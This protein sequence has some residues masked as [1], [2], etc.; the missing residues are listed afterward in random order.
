M[1]VLG[2]EG[3]TGPRLALA[4]AGSPHP[5]GAAEA[6]RRKEVSAEMPHC[7]ERGSLESKPLFPRARAGRG[8]REIRAAGRCVAI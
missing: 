8:S 3:V 4:R 7:W 6:M 2:L 5:S 1:F